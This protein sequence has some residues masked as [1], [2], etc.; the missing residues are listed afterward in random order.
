MSIVFVPFYIKLMGAEAYGIVGV[1]VSLVGVLAVLDFGLS[2]TMNREMARLSHDSRNDLQIN[3]TVHTLEVIYWAMAVFVGVGVCLLAKPIT[4]YWLNPDALNLQEIQLAIQI[5]G[6]VMGLRWPVSF[7]LGGLNGLERQVVVNVILAS[8]ATIQG[9]GALLV[10]S[11]IEPTIKAF[12]IWQAII[13]L[14]QVASLKIVLEKNLPELSKRY[15]DIS[16]LRGL[17]RFTAGVSGISLFATILTQ[18]D[19]VI[20]SKILSLT[21]FG[22]YTF[23]S[24]VAAFTFRLVGP[25]FT[26]YY[27]RLTRIVAEADLNSLAE[28]Y[29]QGSQVMSIVLIPIAVVVIFFSEE[30]LTIWTNDPSLVNNASLLVSLLVVGNTLNGIMHMPYALQLAHG[31]TSLALYQN[32]TAVIV[33]APLIYFA[34]L[35]WGAVGAVSCWIAL[36]AF[37]LLVVNHFM[38][39]RLLRAE[40]WR[41]YSNDLFKPLLS[42]VGVCLVGRSLLQNEV[43]TK[44]TLVTVIVSIITSTFL[45]VFISENIRRI[46]LKHI[47]GKLT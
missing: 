21:D 38:H 47:I 44:L 37:Y 4:L 12:F 45:A 40:K 28:R 42:V 7:Y 16:L 35:H 27:P 34:S 10:L 1:Y 9:V 26:A 3:N 29:H 30:I 23:A 11:F 6:L 17:W 41:W 13:A 19:K 31:W 39:R 20:L 15:W 36:N 5:I 43:D 22:Y 18:L 8:T 32:I 25:V 2:Q 14:I 24:T 33:L 46:T